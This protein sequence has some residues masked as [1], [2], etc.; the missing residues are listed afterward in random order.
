[1]PKK[2]TYEY[3]KEQIEKVE[4]FILLS[5]EY[6]NAHS[7][8]LIQCPKG[9]KFPMCWASFKNGQRCPQCTNE[10]PGKPGYNKKLTYEYVKK[11]IEGEGFILL[12]TEYVGAH[13][14]LL[15]QCPKGHK[16]S[17]CWANFK[18]G[19][20]CPQCYAEKQSSKGEKEVLQT[21]KYF[22]NETILENDRTQI[23]NPLTGYNLELDIWIPSLKKAIEYNGT[24]WHSG[25][26]A[27]QKDVEKQKQ[28][29]EKGIELLIIEDEHWQDARELCEMRIKKFFQKFDNNDY[30]NTN[31]FIK[32]K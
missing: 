13:S 20:R 17:M 4:G 7:K 25:I 12:S 5:T 6:V 10:K 27:K 9:H 15:I 21:V 31:P 2:L 29:K 16:F 22:T 8:L 32:E 30:I 26:N 19:R 28:C 18:N 23:I 3:V 24:Y 11:F 14:K 1:M